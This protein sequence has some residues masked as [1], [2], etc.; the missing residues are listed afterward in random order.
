MVEILSNSITFDNDLRLKG[1]TLSSD[2][3]LKVFLVSFLHLIVFLLDIH[4][5]AVFDSFLLFTNYVNVLICL[6]IEGSKLKVI[7]VMLEVAYGI[8]KIGMVVIVLFCLYFC[9]GD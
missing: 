8:L 1:C 5:Y 6:I 7:H 9:V 2:V 3:S 4:L